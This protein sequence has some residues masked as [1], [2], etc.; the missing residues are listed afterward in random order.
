MAADSPWF[1]KSIPT[2]FVST[3]NPYHLYDI[4]NVSTFVNAYTGNQP[5]IDA[6]VKKMTGKEKFEGKSPV[7]PFCGDFSTKL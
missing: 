3:A 1:M 4:P 7:D 6:V 2:V 5:S